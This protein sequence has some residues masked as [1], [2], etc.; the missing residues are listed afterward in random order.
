M[1]KIAHINQIHDIQ[2]PKEIETII[3]DTAK[4]LDESYGV[5]RDV[6]GGD[7]GYVIFIE[8]ED[9][10]EL[11]KNIHLN[12][13]SVIPEYIDIIECK[14]GATYINVLI[15]LSSDYAINLIFPFNY[16]IYTG[17]VNE[18]PEPYN[19]F[20]RKESRRRSE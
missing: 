4:I 18:L 14:N 20:I 12:V 13:K 8:N 19:S 6:D 15:L 5:D 9:E 1:K 3:Q 17:W 16:I 2:L 7:G 11:L 10:F